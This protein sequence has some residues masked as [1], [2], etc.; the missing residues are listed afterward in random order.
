MTSSEFGRRGAETLGNIRAKREITSSEFGRH[1]AETLGNF[2]AKR[3]HRQNLVGEV[4]NN[5]A[6]PS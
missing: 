2:R 5:L 1:R 6:I 4:R 3:S